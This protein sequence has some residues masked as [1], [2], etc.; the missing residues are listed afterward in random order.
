MNLGLNYRSKAVQIHNN[1]MQ[2]NAF[3]K[4]GAFLNLGRTLSH[5]KKNE[6]SKLMNNE[7][8]FRNSFSFHRGLESRHREKANSIQV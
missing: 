5:E 2:W 3:A 7:N 8:C 4:C 1:H 6:L